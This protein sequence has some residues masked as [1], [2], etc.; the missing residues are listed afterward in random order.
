MLY[1]RKNI[2]DW[3]ALV[4]QGNIIKIR[5]WEDMEKEYDYSSSEN[6][7]MCEHLFTDFMKELCGKEFKITKE[8]EEDFRK[9]EHFYIEYFYIDNY[10]DDVDAKEYTIISTDMIES[11]KTT[12]DIVIDKITFIPD[13]KKEEIIKRLEKALNFDRE[14]YGKMKTIP[15]VYFTETVQNELQEDFVTYNLI[16]TVKKM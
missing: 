6:A 8:M 5:Q 9:Y 11:I 13:D 7:I 1:E 12:D 15:L 3:K 14:F 4:K 10:S 2:K 16:E